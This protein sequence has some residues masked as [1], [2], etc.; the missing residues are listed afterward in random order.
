MNVNQKSCFVS[1]LKSAI[2]MNMK[3]TKVLI[4]SENRVKIE[5]VRQSFSKFFNPLE[6]HG[7]SVDSGVS[8]QPFDEET[9]VGAKNRAEQAKRIS[10]EQHL[11]ANFFVGIEGGVLQLHNRW[12]QFT[13]IHILDQQHRE[14]F[15]TTGLYELPDRIVEKLLAGIELSAIIDKLAGDFNTKEKQSASGFFTKGAVDRLQNYTQ[16]VTF[17]LIPFLNDSL[18]FQRK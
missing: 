12:F 10:D 9:F 2:M 17:A 11:N 5:S 1:L 14:S 15:G 16:A 13:V 8:A 4:G 7:L 3:P 18:Y 6:I